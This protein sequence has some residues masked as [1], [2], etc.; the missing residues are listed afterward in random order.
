MD[1]RTVPVSLLE[2]PG[3]FLTSS[4]RVPGAVLFLPLLSYRRSAE[5]VFFRKISPEVGERTV[6]DNPIPRIAAVA[7]VAGRFS[8]PG[9]KTVAPNEELLLIGEVWRRGKCLCGVFQSIRGAGMNTGEVLLNEI[10]EGP[11][12]TY[13]WPGDVR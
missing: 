11:F 2:I 9:I 1:T 3:H 7:T 6:R 10:T 8:L 5:A 4:L 13:T 12:V